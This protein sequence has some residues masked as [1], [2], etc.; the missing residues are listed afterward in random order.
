MSIGKTRNDDLKVRKAKLE[1][2]IQ[3]TLQKFSYR[4]ISLF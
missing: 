1:P 3:P 4:V 2:A